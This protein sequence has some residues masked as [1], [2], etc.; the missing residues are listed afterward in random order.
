MIRVLIAGGLRLP[1]EAMAAVVA[2]IPGVRVVAQVGTGPQVTPCALRTDPTLAVLDTDLPGL[3]GI[4]AA[5]RLR[6]AVASCRIVLVT[7]PNRPDLL[8]RALE[9]PVDGLLSRSASLDALTHIV[10]RVAHGE[11]VIEPHVVAEALHTPDNPLSASDIDI[12]RLA[13]RGHTPEEI[14]VALHLSA[15]TIRNRLA[16]INRKSGTRNRIETLAVATRR[17]WI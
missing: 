13:A 14:G 6:S 5:Q 12:L 1:R 16:A 2:D 8:R 11:T 17:G 10:S 4:A 3:D 7:P 15:G 9:V